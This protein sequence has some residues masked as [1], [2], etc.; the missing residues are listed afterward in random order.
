M[1]EQKEKA[2]V[3]MTRHFKEQKNYNQQ[4]FLIYIAHKLTERSN[5]NA[6]KPMLSQEPVARPLLLTTWYLYFSIPVPTLWSIVCVL[7]VLVPKWCEVSIVLRGAWLLHRSL[8]RC[9]CFLSLTTNYIYTLTQTRIGGLLCILETNNVSIWNAWLTITSVDNSYWKC[10]PFTLR[11]Q[12]GLP[13]FW[14]PLNLHN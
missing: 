13:H 14:F 2:I 4:T 5:R 9:D 8:R 6:W 10:R 11:W 12:C 1:E 3:K 7:G